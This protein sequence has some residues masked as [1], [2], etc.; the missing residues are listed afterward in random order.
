[1]PMIE[2]FRGV[3]PFLAAD[4]VRLA[5]VVLIPAVSLLLPHLIGG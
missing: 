3:M 1:V 4:T 2:T 5:L